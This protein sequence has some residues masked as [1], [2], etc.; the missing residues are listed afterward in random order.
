M[1]ERD[2]QGELERLKEALQKANAPYRATILA[3]L[4][5]NALHKA[6]A[7]GATDHRPFHR[8]R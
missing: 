2:V 3:P 4:T 5:L 6:L 1:V 7:P 8:P